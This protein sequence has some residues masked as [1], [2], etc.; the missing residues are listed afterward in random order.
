MDNKLYYTALMDGIKN[1]FCEAMEKLHE[2]YI[3]SWVTLYNA[4]FHYLFPSPNVIRMIIKKHD[5][6]D[7]CSKRRDSAKCRVVLVLILKERDFCRPDERWEDYI[8]I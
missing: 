2:I 1:S 5:I 7:V 8:E 6:S 4:D 3:R